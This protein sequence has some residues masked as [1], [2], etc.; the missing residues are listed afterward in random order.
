[1]EDLDRFMR[2][3]GARLQDVAQATGLAES[4]VSRLR[5]RIHKHPEWETVQSI[6]DWAD[7]EARRLKLKRDQ[8]LE[9][10]VRRRPR[11]A[12]AA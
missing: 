10:I 2:L 8:W 5:N 3:V 9:P 7:S 11:R 1:M 4:T 6:C 12:G